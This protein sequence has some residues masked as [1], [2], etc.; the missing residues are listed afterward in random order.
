MLPGCDISWRSRLPTYSTRAP[1]PLPELSVSFH[2]GGSCCRK[3]NRGSA[4][5]PTVLPHRTALHRTAPR[6][7]TSHRTAS[8]RTASHRI[9][10]APGRLLL[11]ASS[12]SGKRESGRTGEAGCPRHGSSGLPVSCVA[13][14]SAASSV[15]RVTGPGTHLG[16]KGYVQTPLG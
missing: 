10:P 11:L 2:L 1:G 6:R 15:V 9:A 8:H 5:Q 4:C 16:F 12:G 3:R 14:G 13:A 7:I